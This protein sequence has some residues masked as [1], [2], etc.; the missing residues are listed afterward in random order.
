MRLN[1]NETLG[2][3]VAIGTIFALGELGRVIGKKIASSLRKYKARKDSE[4]YTRYPSIKTV[5]PELKEPGC[6]ED[7]NKYIS[8]TLKEY[9][10]DTP[11]KTQKK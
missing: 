3:I 10:I 4:V 6:F 2:L 8:E 1:E 5:R 9:R 11:C 7:W